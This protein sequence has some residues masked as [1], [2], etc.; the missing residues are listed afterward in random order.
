LEAG[1][2][3]ITTCTY[4]ASFEGFRRAGYDETDAITLMKKG[5]DLADQA[6]REH[7]TSSKPVKVALS[8][9]CYGAIL[10]NGTEY[11]GMN[12]KKKNKGL[13]VWLIAVGLSKSST[14]TQPQ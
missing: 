10:A 11:S 1:A 12:R 6:R 2:E 4:Q 14:H 9:G 7:K 8:I 13:I 3:I 5:V